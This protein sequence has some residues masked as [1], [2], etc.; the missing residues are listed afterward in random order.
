M[1]Q[2]SVPNT[3]CAIEWL[4]SARGNNPLNLESSQQPLKFVRMVTNL[5]GRVGGFADVF[6]SLLGDFL[7]GLQTSVNLFRKLALGV[8][9]SGDLT[10][11]VRYGGYGLSDSV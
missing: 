1:W 7:N 3:R 2:A 11:H 4:Q 9:G 5:H 6:D 8:G 10:I